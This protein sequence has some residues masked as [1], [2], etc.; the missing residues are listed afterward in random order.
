MK[1]QVLAAGVAGV[2][3][4][5][6]AGC[7]KP[8]P[9]V[10]VWSGTSSVVR[11]ATCWAP[12]TTVTQA[13]RDCIAHATSQPTDSIPTLEVTPGDVVGIN[14]DEPLVEATWLPSVGGQ[15]LSQGPIDESYFRFTYPNVETP[16]E[17]FLLAVTARGTA[18]DQ[19]RGL[20][21]FRLVPATN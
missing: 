11:P 2:A 15:A 14:V 17:G 4:L 21:L 3:V 12:D 9:E 8:T 16:P 19:D 6:L 20:W 7:T 1:L 18:A 13:V 5:A 10:T